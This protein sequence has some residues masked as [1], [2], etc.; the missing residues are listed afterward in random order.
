MSE[1]NVTKS[2][3]KNNKVTM[4]QAIHL[5]SMLVQLYIYFFLAE[6]T[7]ILT[8]TKFFMCADTNFIL[9]HNKN[10]YAILLYN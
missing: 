1:N 3:I 2:V 4:I 9:C 10:I 7:L 6:L 5:I 8:V